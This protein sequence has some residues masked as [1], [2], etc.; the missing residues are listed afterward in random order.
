VDIEETTLRRSLIWAIA[1]GDV[2]ADQSGLML[3]KSLNSRWGLGMSKQ[4]KCWIV[5]FNNNKDIGVFN[6]KP[7]WSEVYNDWD[8]RGIGLG[9]YNNV[10]PQTQKMWTKALWR[11]R[12]K[13]SIWECV[14]ET[15]VPIIEIDCPECHGMSH[16]FVTL[17]LYSCYNCNHTGKIKR[18]MEPGDV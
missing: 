10:A 4:R 16:G 11:K 6:E 5:R 15:W 2:T 7:V 12:W 9:Y 1:F 17:D 3:M 18:P 8:C 13:N 14:W